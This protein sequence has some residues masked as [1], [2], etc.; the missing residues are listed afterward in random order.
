MEVESG[1]PDDSSLRDI[2]DY[3]YMNTESLLNVACSN[4]MMSAKTV[5]PLIES[6]PEMVKKIY[7]HDGC[8]PLHTL[9]KDKEMGEQSAVNIL[10][11][12]IRAY[13]EAVDK[14]VGE[15]FLSRLVGS[16]DRKFAIN[17]ARE[18]HVL[19]VL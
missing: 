12:F 7:K 1:D 3:I 14:L 11:V 18:Q 10:K 15:G 16:N 5:S 2:E 6:C 8:L 13:P 4:P 9:C 19:Q 17:L